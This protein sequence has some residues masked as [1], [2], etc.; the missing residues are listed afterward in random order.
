MRGE[1][2]EYKEE[3]MKEREVQREEGKDCQEWL[4]QEE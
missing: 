1:T 2:E 4:Q 3:R